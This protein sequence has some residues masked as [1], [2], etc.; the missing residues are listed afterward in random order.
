MPG[1]NSVGIFIDAANLVKSI[2]AAGYSLNL[3][4][5]RRYLYN[6]YT[7][8]FIRYYTASYG[9]NDNFIKSL[10]AKGFNVVTKPIKRIK[11]ASNSYINKANFDVE[12]SVDAMEL[13]N[14]LSM[15]I[16]FSGDSDFAYLV[17]NLRTKSKLVYCYSVQYHISRELIK[18][19]DKYFDILK[20]G[21]A[22]LSKKQKSPSFSTGGLSSI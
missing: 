8:Q 5:F 15:I 19:C 1:T 10:I 20:I 13:N 2:N 6:E 16:L 14:H 7:P 4:K 18:V 12:I 22:F 11:T 3:R 9:D 17:K 21:K